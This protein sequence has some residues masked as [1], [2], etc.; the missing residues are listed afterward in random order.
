MY[1]HMWSPGQCSQ[2]S[3]LLRAEWCRDHFRAVARFSV[4]I[5]TGPEAHPPYF[6]TKFVDELELHL[7]LPSTPAQACRGV[8][9]TYMCM[10][11]SFER[12]STR[13]EK[14]AQAGGGKISE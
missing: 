6:S 5:Q 9:F 10:F 12:N 3:D 2:Y 14:M 7:H 11:G 4:P 13:Q 1:M 8:T